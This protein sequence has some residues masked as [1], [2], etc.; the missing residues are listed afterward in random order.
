MNIDAVLRLKANVSGENNIKRLGNSMQGV[1]GKVKNLSGS[2]GKLT[3]A[4]K[5]LIGVAAAGAFTNY[6]K[7]AIDAA[8]A[9]GK[10]EVRT[11][12][13]AGKLLGYINAGKLAD[14]SQKQ[15]VTGLRTLARTQA[16][17]ADGVA[18]YSEAYAR[19]GVKVEDSDGNLKASD[20]LLGEIA[21]RFADLPDGPQKA[22]I[23]MDLFGKSG[24]DLITL[25]NGGSKALEE[26]NFGLS[27]KFAQNAEFYNDQVQKLT[28]AF[29][30]FKLQLMDALM[31][32]LIEITNV[33]SELFA[34]EVDWRSFFKLVEGGLRGIAAASLVVVEGFRFL[35]R[36]QSD[37]FSIILTA[38][39]GDLKGAVAIATR[40]LGEEF[41]RAKENFSR[42]GRIFTGTTEA[43]EGYGR[44]FTGRDVED[45]P[46]KT[47][48]GKTTKTPE[49]KRLEDLAKI[50]AKLIQLA[51]QDDQRLRASLAAIQQETAFADLR[52][53]KGEEF[54][55]QTERIFN[56]VTSGEV[57]SFSEAFALVEAQENLRKL[58][59]A[60]DEANR[61]QEAQAQK[62]KNLYRSVG[63]AITSSIGSA[64]E[65]LIDNTKSLGESLADLAKSLG[66]MFLR[67]GVQSLLGT[68]GFADGGVFNQNKIVPFA[69]GGLVNKPTIFPM[70]NGMGLMGE[71]GPEAI[72]PLRRDSS[73]RLGVEAAGGGT[74]IVVNVDAQGTSVQGD[75]GK[76]R[77]LGSAIST[78]VQ[79][80]LIKQQRPGGLLAR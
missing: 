62:L 29:D 7:S 24:A 40:G 14:V 79:A 34:S 20:K 8:D 33:F 77:Q 43:P 67:F 38:F 44:R 52:L 23:A 59:E 28:F 21:D 76:S 30:K 68:I 70:A 69:R 55:D 58:Q 4:F 71:A 9:L 53:R 74:S 63:S 49:E 16:E 22:A 46:E 2:V 66:R 6:I 11:G 39:R 65:G 1:Q 48:P 27:K 17:A 10:L 47:K 60:Q 37:V 75:E 64:I 35:G 51:E 15:L 56:M 36:V 42:L 18:T 26:F 45:L 78:A 13:A 31:P 72:M 41:E 50:D 32:A 3:K 57:E 54:A 19:L 5:T 61:K 80:E 12:I 73:G 25:L